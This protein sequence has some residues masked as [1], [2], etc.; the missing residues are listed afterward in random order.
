MNFAPGNIVKVRERE[1]VVLPESTDQLLMIRPLGG[2]DAEVTGVLPELETV[3]PA[4]LDYPDPENFGDHRSGRML[5]D[6]VR[7]GFRSSAGPFRS[8]ARLSFEPRPYQLVPLLMALRQEPVRLLIADDVGIGK[9]VEALLIARE[10]LDRGEIQRIA[11]LCPPHLAEQWRD[12]M[13]E[14]FNIDATLVLPGTVRK[15]ESECALNQSLFEVNPFVVVSTD[16]IKSDRRRDEFLRTC[17]EFVIVDEAHT[18]ASGAVS[19]GASHQRHRLVE[20]L[21]SDEKRHLVLVTATPHSGNEGAFRSLLGLIKPEFEQLPDDLSGRQNESLR[22]EL[23]K[24]LVQRRRADLRTYLECDTSFPDRIEA[25]QSYTLSPEYAKFVQRILS[26]ARE[27]AT[28]ESG[29]KFR[30]RIR[31]WSVLALLRAISSSPAA[32]AATLRSRAS[33]LSASSVEEVDSIGRVTVLDSLEEESAEGLDVTPGSDSDDEGSDDRTR[34]RLQEFAREADKLY[35]EKDFKL[36]NIAEV[37]K[38]FVKEGFS[39]IVFCRFIHTSEYVADQLR[40]MLRGVEIASVTGLLPPEE[41]E[42][43]IEELGKHEKKIL[44]CTDC[45][46]EGINLQQ[47]FDAVIHYDL[48]WLPTRHEQREGRVDRFNQQSPTVRVLTYWGKNNQIDG[49]VLDVLL[50]K[51]KA[52]RKDLQISVPLPNATDDL[53]EA[54]FEGLLLREQ[55]GT[56]P[57]Q[58]YLALDDFL[59]PKR[60]QLYVE[61]ER[62]AEKEKRSR[63]IFTQQSIKFDEVAKELEAIHAAIGDSSIVSRFTLDALRSLGAA[64]TQNGGAR[65]DI[66]EL[67]QGLK[68]TLPVG[69]QSELNISFG[70]PA[71]KGSVYLHRTHPIVEALAN[72]AMNVALDPL[73]GDELPK[74]GFARRA[75]ITRTSKIQKLTTLILLRLRY[76]LEKIQGDAT[77]SLLVEDSMILAFEGLPKNARWLETAEVDALMEIRPEGNVL[78]EQGAAQISRIIGELSSIQEAINAKVEEHGADL[79]E[80]HSR[81][82]T[83]SN[84]RGLRYKIEPV[85]PA[86]LLGIYLFQPLHP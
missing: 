61:W 1:W 26:Y 64:V 76:Q 48:A 46:S 14:K 3:T 55:G 86:D 27:T 15:L 13:A 44:V 2:A 7:L 85:L 5:R 82:R 62:S 19:K 71:P 58:L 53:I 77:Q 47:H 69:E 67:P 42:A 70:L 10:L 21:S 79:L 80:A 17:P 29:G 57:E 51:H 54:L 33:T 35:G 6:A 38:Q 28:D 43:R 20:G 73:A 25:E 30:Q 16:F 32:A 4:D 9:T 60:D 74:H 68:D 63:S 23:A 66:S 36:T 11:V 40:S 45:L 83:A 50:R 81:V 72:Y 49:I 41:R 31:W 84:I 75:G 39:P 18:C 24:Y 78:A 22:R 59:R 8:F 65:V 52:I 12:E 37:L 34:R 56:A